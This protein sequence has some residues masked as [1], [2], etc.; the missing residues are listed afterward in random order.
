MLELKIGNFENSEETNEF[1]TFWR[2]ILAKEDE[3]LKL[4]AD[5]IPEDPDINYGH[6]NVVEKNKVS[7]GNVLGGG[8][9]SE[10]FSELKIN[11]M[12]G[13]FG[14]VPNSVIEQFVN[15]IVTEI[16]DQYTLEKAEIDMWYD[17]ETS[18]KSS[19]QHIEM[20]KNLGYEFD[21]QK[22]VIEL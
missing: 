16:K 18:T 9:I 17:P 15:M 5:I 22:R 6:R 12:S 8:D 10:M 4:Y 20:W 21:D 13:D 19:S 2:F 3:T 1:G 11:G 14:I 7:R